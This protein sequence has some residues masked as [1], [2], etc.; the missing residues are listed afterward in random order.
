MTKSEQGDGKFVEKPPEV[1]LTGTEVSRNMTF[2]KQQNDTLVSSL[3]QD[4]RPK[5]SHIFWY[6]LLPS[7]WELGYPHRLRKYE[8]MQRNK[9]AF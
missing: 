5:L 4:W 3:Q 8:Q 2:P 6:P 9:K 7:K 1:L